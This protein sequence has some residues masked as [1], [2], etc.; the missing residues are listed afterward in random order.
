MDSTNSCSSRDHTKPVMRKRCK[1]QVR[2]FYSKGAF[3]V[4]LWTTLVSAAVWSYGT[5]LGERILSEGIHLERNTFSRVFIVL[6]FLVYATIPLVG[7]LADAKLGNYRVLKFSCFFLVVA[8]ITICINILCDTKINFS[9]LQYTRKVI[10]G[11]VYAVSVASTA[12]Y[13]ITALQLGLD[14]MPDASSTNISSF[15][16]WFVFSLT[17]GCWIAEWLSNTL[18]HCVNSST[19]NDIQKMQL[20]SLFPVTCMVVICSS[21]FL[22]A[23]KWLIIEP[24]SP[25]ALKTI[26]QVLKFAAKHKAPIYRSALTYWEEAVPSRLDLGKTKYGGPFTTE[27]VEDV[28]TFLQ[29]IVMSFPIF[30]TVTACWNILLVLG[31]TADSY[32]GVLNEEM[33]WHLT[34]SNTTDNCTSSIIY[35]FSLSHW[36]SGIVTTVVYEFALYPLIRNKVPSSIRRI[37]GATLF[38]LLLNML[39]LAIQFSPYAQASVLYMGALSGFLSVLLINGILEFVCAQSP[40]NM[41]GLLTGYMMFLLFLSVSLNYFFA[42]L[43]NEIYLPIYTIPSIYTALS[44]IGLVLYCLLARRYKRRVRDEDYN[45]HRVVEEVYDRYLSHVQ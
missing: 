21:M 41:R 39:K 30:L 36:W 32:V 9:A 14:Q 23:P 43:P 16:S 37:G 11:L 1:Y 26:Y 29:I 45:A 2:W 10:I 38:I 20:F 3:L 28:K 8:S 33:L 42:M 6:P 34:V 18:L 5:M 7:W 40:Y 13:I 4:L 22:L 27:Q 44:V 24:K 19:I 35:T 15:I 12:I 25:K 31:F 17:L